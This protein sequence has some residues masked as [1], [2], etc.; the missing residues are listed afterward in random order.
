MGEMVRVIEGLKNGII[1]RAINNVTIYH[2]SICPC[3][4]DF[5]LGRLVSRWDRDLGRP[6]LN[7]LPVKGKS[8]GQSDEHE[9][10]DPPRTGDGTEE[11]AIPIYLGFPNDEVPREKPALVRCLEYLGDGSK[12]VYRN[13]DEKPRVEISKQGIK[14]CHGDLHHEGIKHVFLRD[15]VI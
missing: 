6:S 11:H 14:Q 2:R 15:Q 13:K 7:S 5:H 1:D 3:P 4:A 9:R 8:K 10:H 12:N